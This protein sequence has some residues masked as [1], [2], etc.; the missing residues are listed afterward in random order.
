MQTVRTRAEVRDAAGS[1]FVDAAGHGSTP[2]TLDVRVRAPEAARTRPIVITTAGNQ[3]DIVSAG[4]GGASSSAGAGAGRGGAAAAQAR[5]AGGAVAITT[6]GNG[7]LAGGGTTASSPGHGN[8][9]HG[10]AAPHGLD[11]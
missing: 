11:R 10:H 9:G 6:A 1:R 7:S 2:G 8:A 3:T 4:R 5:G